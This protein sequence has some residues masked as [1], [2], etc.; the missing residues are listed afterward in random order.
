MQILA[1]LKAILINVI[2]Y[3]NEAN[4]VSTRI[5]FSMEYW[6]VIHS[7]KIIDVGDVRRYYTVSKNLNIEVSNPK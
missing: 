5:P 4:H 7:V 2:P 1:V 3:L 6:M